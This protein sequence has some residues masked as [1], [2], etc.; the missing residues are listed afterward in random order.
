MEVLTRTTWRYTIAVFAGAITL[1]CFFLL[2]QYPRMATVIPLI[3][4]WL[5]ALIGLS[6]FSKT[7][8]VQQYQLFSL[9]IC[10][11]LSLVGLFFVVELPIIRRV[12]MVASVILYAMLFGWNIKDDGLWESIKPF[13]RVVMM[14]W[15]FTVYAG[16]TTLFAFH[17]FFQG[18]LISLI[19]ILGGAL[20][21]SYA[22]VHIWRLY[23]QS[24]I[25]PLILWVMIVGITSVEIIWVVGLLP[26]VYGALG[27]LVTWCWYLL[28]LFARFHFSKRG[29]EWKQQVP[30]LVINALLV[31][32]FFIFFVRWV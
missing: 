4:L 15:V 16:M 13:R 31:I 1:L 25:K 12:V 8:Y 26:F 5:L 21:L 6:F 9:I 24:A 14:S 23:F 17:A 18:T 32:M 2:Q 7:R 10:L 19:T 27:L 3:C 30:F 20:L 22:A 28:Q 11:G 29:I